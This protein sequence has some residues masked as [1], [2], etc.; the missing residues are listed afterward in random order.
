MATRRGGWLRLRWQTR[1]QGGRRGG[2]QARLS[3]PRIPLPL[4]VPLDPHPQRRVQIP[5]QWKGGGCHCWRPHLK[6]EQNRCSGTS[7]PPDPSSLGPVPA[8]SQVYLSLP[9]SKTVSCGWMCPSP[10]PFA[11]PLWCPPC[12]TFECPASQ[13]C[14]GLACSSPPPPPGSPHSP[15]GP[16]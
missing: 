9:G 5:S 16:R 10:L 8:R 12:D 1:V 4:V 11:G 14:L 2:R 13:P 6:I 3:S 15:P 7:Q